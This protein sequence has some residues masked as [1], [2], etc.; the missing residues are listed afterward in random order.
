MLVFEVRRAFERHTA[1]DMRRGFLDLLRREAKPV[2]QQ[3]EVPV[4][5]LLVGQA[6]LVF[7]E[8]FAENEL[9][10]DERQLEGAREHG[11]DAGD[12]FVVEALWP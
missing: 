1:A 3:G 7:A 10:E 12:G 4:V 5:E 2:A 8:L 6:E 11:F 9:I